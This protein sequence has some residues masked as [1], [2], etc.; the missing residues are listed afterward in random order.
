M[1][2][3]CMRSHGA[4]GEPLVPMD[5]SW[6]ADTAALWTAFILTVSLQGKPS[7]LERGVLHPHRLRSKTIAKIIKSTAAFSFALR[8][9]VKSVSSLN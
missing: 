8:T 2:Q 1:I 6:G 7:L 5:P 4:V 9:Q 3:T